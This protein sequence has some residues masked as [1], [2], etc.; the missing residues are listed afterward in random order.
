MKNVHIKSSIYVLVIMSALAWLL[1]AWISHVD[2]SAASSFLSLIPKVVTI[3]LV[4]VFVFTKWGWKWKYF[5]GWLVPFP[6]LHGSWSGN[7]YSD[8]INPETGKK[9]PPIPVLLT[10]NQSFFHVSCKMMVS[11]PH[12][13]SC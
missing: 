5:R 11:A 10:I 8:W 2:M 3:D 13:T 1:L 6:N 4:F 12:S 7:I 9:A